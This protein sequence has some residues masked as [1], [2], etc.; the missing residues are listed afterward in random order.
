L[1]PSQTRRLFQKT[2]RESP[3]RWLIRERLIAAQS[4]MIRDND[5]I[6]SIAEAC[7]FCDVY[8]FGREFKRVVGAS[9]AAWRRAE[10]GARET[11]KTPSRR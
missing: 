1:S 2:L 9:P 10:L 7:G 4:L 11:L 3:R 5:P 6:A 8:H